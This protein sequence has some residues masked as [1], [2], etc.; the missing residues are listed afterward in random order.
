MQKLTARMKLISLKSSGDF[1]KMMPENSTSTIDID[2]ST[3]TKALTK[4]I[5]LY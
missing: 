5:A 3:G 2:Y 1:L 4:G